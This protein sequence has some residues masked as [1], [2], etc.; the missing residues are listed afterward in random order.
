LIADR[1]EDRRSLIL[2]LEADNMGQL[3]EVII[4]GEDLPFSNIVGDRHRFHDVSM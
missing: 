3:G 1:N 4:D 2:G